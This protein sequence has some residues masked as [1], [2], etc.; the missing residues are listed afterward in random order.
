MWLYLSIAS[1]SIL[2]F[3]DVCKKWSVRDNAPLLVL[4]LTVCFGAAMTIPILVWSV[5]HPQSA[6]EVGML[7][8]MLTPYEHALVLSKAAV[9]SI[10]W[11]AIFFALKHLPISIVA[12]IRASAPL[13]TLFGAVLLLGERP[14]ALH[15]IAIAIIL[16][17]YFAFSLIG[18][19]EG[20][21]FSKNRWVFLAFIATL[22]GAASALYDKYL[23]KNAG[24]DP[25][26]LQV[27]FSLYLVVIIGA[28]TAAAHFW[29]KTVF[30]N[31]KWR[32][33]IPAVGILLI[34]SDFLYFRA[35]SSEDA[36]IA[37]VS[38]VRRS[39][40]IISFVVG[41][42]IFHEKN[43]R[44]KAIPLIG[45]LIGVMLLLVKPN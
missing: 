31:F 25:I 37:V 33:T 44:K 9:V 3:Y 21:V 10:S 22:S 38:A 24:I 12:P 5:L 16:I 13:W 29:S 14:T 20:I 8:R 15:L 39:N 40:V 26:S 2:G 45:V 1:A 6:A 30:S 41:G 19:K 4:F 18:K 27:W 11:I 42:L 7:C 34:V 17:S 43:K 28:I 23:L 32:S 35:L 36:L